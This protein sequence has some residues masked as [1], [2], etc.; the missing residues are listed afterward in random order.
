MERVIVGEVS[1]EAPKGHREIFF[2]YLGFRHSILDS[3]MIT[4]D[5]EARGTMSDPEIIF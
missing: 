3:D 1:T 5:P 2:N 4:S